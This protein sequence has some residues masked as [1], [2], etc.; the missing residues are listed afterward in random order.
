VR[1]AVLHFQVHAAQDLLAVDG[2]VEIVD[3]QRVCH[4]NR[5]I[6]N[7]VV[8]EESNMQK[9]QTMQTTQNASCGEAD[10]SLLLVSFWWL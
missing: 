8:M 3:L 1:L 6:Q 9:M 7:L 2:N 10:Q 4:L 5:L